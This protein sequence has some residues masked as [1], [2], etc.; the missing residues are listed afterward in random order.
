MVH[1]YCKGNKKNETDTKNTMKNKKIGWKIWIYKKKYLIL[2]SK[3][4]RQ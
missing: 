1:S 4:S 3:Y 2:Q